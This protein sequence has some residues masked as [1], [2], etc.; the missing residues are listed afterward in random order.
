MPDPA[1]IGPSR[2]S[3][4]LTGATHPK[5]LVRALLVKLLA[6]QF[7]AILI[8][9]AQTLEFQTDIAMQAFVSPIVLGMAGPASFQIDAQS[10]PPSRKPTQPMH[11]TPTG[12]G[13]AVVTA[14]GLRQSVALKE[15]LK[16][17]LRSN[18]RLKLLSLAAVPC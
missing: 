15:P 4:K 1:P 16:T 14:D 7:Q 5:G 12:K 17:L 3:I 13:A 10:D 11:R 6:P 18:T 2:M 8:D 9:P